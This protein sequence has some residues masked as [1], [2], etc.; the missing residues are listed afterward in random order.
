MWQGKA[1]EGKGRAGQGRRCR[2]VNVSGKG[3]DDAV[4]FG[5]GHCRKWRG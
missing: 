1:R 5:N 4:G 2:T 3:I